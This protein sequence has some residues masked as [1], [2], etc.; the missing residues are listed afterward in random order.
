MK[1]TKPLQW[2]GSD[3]S[4]T[5]KRALQLLKLAIVLVL[6]IVIY[7]IVDFDKILKVL[8]GANLYYVGAGF[9]VYIGSIYLTALQFKILAK[10]EDIILSVNQ[11]AAI[12]LSI[13]FYLLFL[14]G[15]FLGSGLRWYKVSQA[16]GKPT[17][18]LAAVAFNRLY[19][20]FLIGVFGLGFWIISG[21]NNTQTYA[22]GLVVILL[23]IALLWIGITRISVPISIWVGFA[24]ERTSQGTLIRSGLE[25]IQK[26]LSAIA[27]YGEISAGDLIALVIVGAARLLVGLVVYILLAR[28]VGINLPVTDMGWIRS[29]V[30]LFAFIPFTIAGG[31]GIREIGLIAMLSAFGISAEVAVAFSILLLGLTVFYGLVGGVIEAIDAIRKGKR[32]GLPKD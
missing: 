4:P 13:M 24:I 22:V 3:A 9:I 12:N 14:P 21:Q 8:A 28:S 18:S 29:V 32:I 23:L 16:R 6:F 11:V 5:A 30:L 20:L 1:F 15:T 2:L 19:D 10:Q 17:E 7:W 31:L 25:K 27:V 26:L